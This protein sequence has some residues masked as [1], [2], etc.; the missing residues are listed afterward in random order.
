MEIQEVLTDEARDTWQRAETDKG[1]ET[2]WN[3]HKK[4]V[5]LKPWTLLF[6]HWGP[7]RGN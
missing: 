2:G 3:L 7:N 1:R 4:C 6:R 5:P